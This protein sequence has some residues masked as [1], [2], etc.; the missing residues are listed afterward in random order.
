MGRLQYWAIMTLSS[1]L[2]LAARARLTARFLRNPVRYCR[3][4][5]RRA[6]TFPDPVDGMAHLL[7]DNNGV[8]LHVATHGLGTGKP[9]MLF[10]HGFPETWA[11]WRHQIQEFAGQYELVAMDMRGYGESDA[12]KGVKN[13]TIDYLVSDV[14]VVVKAAGHAKCILVA[15]DWGG[16]VAWHTAALCPEVVDKLVVL[17]SPHPAAFK[18]PKRF[19]GEQLK[20]SSYMM[21]MLSSVAESHIRNSDFREVE[22]MLVEAPFGARRAG[23]FSQQDI[24]RVKAALARPGSLTGGL[25]YYRAAIAQGTKWRLEAAERIYDTPVVAPTLLMWAD[26]D[27]AFLPQMFQQGED[28]LVEQLTVVC[29]RDCSHWANQDRPEQPVL[30]RPA[31][32]SN[33]GS[34]IMLKVDASSAT[35]VPSSPR[36]GT[37]RLVPKQD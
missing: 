22:R 18:D 7:V 4:V 30:G 12:P 27:L 10:L 24:D 20:R 29:L 2:W 8:K 35:G 36:P 32:T 26:Q 31:S 16:S 3:K 28:K 6:M 19:T 37:P 21:M 25:N 23:T 9:L 14:L 13:Y 34:M 17:C 5:D 11:S 15:H 1:P 33:R